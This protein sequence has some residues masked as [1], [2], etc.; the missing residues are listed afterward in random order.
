METR[1]D[2]LL[3]TMR[4][5]KNTAFFSKFTEDGLAPYL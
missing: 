2:E 1:L 4:S 3:A 5:L